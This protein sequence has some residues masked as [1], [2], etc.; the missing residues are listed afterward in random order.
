MLNAIK[1]VPHI[2]F[3]TAEILKDCRLT[4]PKF[5][6]DIQQYLDRVQHKKLSPDTP[7]LQINNKFPEGVKFC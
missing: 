7:P 3:K 5:K 4:H 1:I 6:Q 2:L